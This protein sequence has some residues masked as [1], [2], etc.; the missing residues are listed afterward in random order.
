[1]TWSRVVW[2]I[3][4]ALAFAATAALA[5]SLAR[6]GSLHAS[7]ASGRGSSGSSASALARA[8]PDAREATAVPLC[9]TSRL[10]ITVRSDGGIGRYVVEFTNVSRAACS[11]RG[12]PSVSAYG[13][14]KRELGT[15][16]ARDT[17]VAVRLVVLRRGESA[18]SPVA[19]TARSLP[20]RRCRPVTAAGLRVVPPGQR[21]GS[22]IQQSLTAC[23]AQGTDAPVFLRV[24]A[25]QPG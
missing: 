18:A 14:G 1:M 25:V 11:L 12:Y 2:R 17:S 15:A 13:P 23:S 4:A 19:A 21:A 24:R 7:L 16:G 6:S 20:T 22:L 8:R 5:I 3:A 9:Q 10:H